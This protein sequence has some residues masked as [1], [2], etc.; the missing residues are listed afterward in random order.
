M[1]LLQAALTNAGPD[2][3]V[4]GAQT[5]GR[6]SEPHSFSS[7]DTPALRSASACC[8]LPRAEQEAPRAVRRAERIGKRE[9][10][11]ALAVLYQ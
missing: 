7:S 2:T 8:R 10:S 6:M 11:G 9:L 3:M 5:A 4:M 1:P